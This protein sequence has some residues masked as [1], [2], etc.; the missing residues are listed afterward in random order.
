MMIPEF[1]GTMWHLIQFIK[2]SVPLYPKGVSSKTPSGS[3]KPR[4]APNHSPLLQP[5]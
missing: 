2:G 5:C 3:L 1:I 4:R